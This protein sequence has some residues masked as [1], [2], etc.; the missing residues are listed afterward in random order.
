MKKKHLLIL[1]IVLLSIVKVNVSAK[2]CNYN[3]VDVE[4]EDNELCLELDYPSF[5]GFDLNENQ[6]INQVIAWFYSF[7]VTISGLAVFAKLVQGGFNWLSS[8]GNSTKTAEAT[9]T[10]TSALIGLIIVLSS[11]IIIKTINPELTT[12]ILPDIL[13]D[14]QQ[15]GEI[16]NSEQ[17]QNSNA[18]CSVVLNLNY[19]SPNSMSLPYLAI[20]YEIKDVSLSSVSEIKLYDPYYTE[21]ETWSVQGVTEGETMTIKTFDLTYYSELTG[22]WTAEIEGECTDS[23]TVD[24]NIYD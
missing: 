3:G 6:D 20:G 13:P 5:G 12:L 10:I 21:M 18:S 9:E 16:E 11:F 19:V 15:I 7:I 4:V 1:I 22:I 24:V 14:I 8:A 2:T 23:A 17:T